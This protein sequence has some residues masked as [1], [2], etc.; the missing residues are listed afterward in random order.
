MP[1]INAIRSDFPIL[2][3]T[4]HGKPLVYLDS[5]ATSQKPRQVIEALARYYEQDNANVHRGV[6]TLAERATA[7]Y[8]Q[9]RLKI[10][11]FI[12]AASS[13]EVVFVRNTTEAINLVA[14]AWGRANLRPGDEVLITQ[15]EHHSNIVPW[16]LVTQATGATLRYVPIT[17]AG[18]LDYDALDELLTERTRV[19][20]FTAMSNVL[21]TIN[22]VAELVAR[23]HAVGAIAVVDGAQSV[24]HLITDVQA[25]D[26]DFLAFSG[27]KMLGPTGIGALYGKRALLDAMPPFMGGGEM[28][29]E[30][31]ME[32]STWNDVPFKFEAGTPAIGEAI[33]FGAAVDYLNALGMDWVHAHEQAIT[34]YAWERLS[35][36]EGLRIIGPEPER[37]GGLIAFTLADVHPHDVAAVLDMHGVAVRAGHHC[38]QPIHDRYGI[39]ATARASFYVYNTMEEVDV[40]AEALERA[41]TLFAF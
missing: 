2:S 9:A 41:R 33:A 28:I 4:A 21:G 34:R 8:E 37:R 13:K 3:Q 26:A 7:E 36:I 6:H 39:P 20:A 40:L 24:P 29:R 10:A 19:F 32:R 27:H 30:V 1:D 5:T 17:D 15:M 14:N 18:E 35:A 11:R 16:Q 22:P 31:F 25:T 23:A 38:A 12:N